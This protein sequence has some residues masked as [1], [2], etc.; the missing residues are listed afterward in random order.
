MRIAESEL[1]LNPD[2]SIYHIN[3][4][5]ENL[6]DKIILVGD[7]H[8]VP[9]VSSFFDTIEFKTEKREIVTHTGTFE[10]ERFTVISTGMGPDN[11]DIVLTELDAVANVDFEKR[12]PR[13][14]HRPLTLVRMGTSGSFQADIPVDSFVAALYT[15]GFDNLMHSYQTPEN[16]FETDIENAFIQHTQWN[17]NMGRPYVI[18][19]N[20]A[21]VNSM[22]GDNTRVGF[23]ATAGGFYGPQGREIRLQA[24]DRQL[25]DK[26]TAF[27]YNDLRIT[28]MEMETSA[29]Y[30]L[31]NLL[32]HRACSMNC[33]VANRETGEFS[34]DSYKSVKKMIEYSLYKMKEI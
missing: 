30:G 1:I 24:R 7:P 17:P 34:Q 14:Q 4:R 12:E 6:A 23:T 29:I 33:I 9:T 20:E 11:I 10:G 16:F 26:I 27:R 19:T 21:L 28:N 8:R 3:L 5:P 2:G 18:K 32:G 13:S 22:L 31:S 25:N 15:I